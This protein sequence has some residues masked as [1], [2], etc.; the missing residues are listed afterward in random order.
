MFER[1]PALDRNSVRESQIAHRL[2]ALFDVAIRS[3][4]RIEVRGLENFTQAP[5]TLVVSNHRR[6]SDG[7]IIASV[8]LQREKLRVRGVM[9]YFV[10]REDLFR[11]G[12]LREYLE[13]WPSPVRAALSGLD[14]APLLQLMQAAPMRRV[15]ERSLMEVLEEVLEVFGDLRLDKVLKP[16]WVRE[17]ER[18]AGASRNQPLRVSDVLTWRYHKLLS[19]RHGLLKLTRQR[20][21]ALLP[22]ERAIIESQL[23]FFTRLLE[24]GQTLLLE[25]EGTVSVDGRFARLRAGL[26][27]LL[28]RPA[29]PPRVLPVGITYDFIT[30]NPKRVL[31]SVGKEMRNLQ[32]LSRK[33]TDKRVAAAI[34]GQ[35]CITCSQ[36]ASDLLFQVR[37]RGDA[38]ITGSEIDCYVRQE[39]SRYAQAGSPVD[40]RLLTEDDR[41]KRV[42]EYIRHCLRNRILLRRGRDRYCLAENGQE[43]QPSADP[44]GDIIGYMHNELTTL[45]GLMSDRAGQT[46]PPS[47][48]GSSTGTSG[49]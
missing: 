2:A 39:A 17:F 29:M 6:D 4:Y 40:S 38:S 8:L 35:L 14:L 42:R 19:R 26:H 34:Q 32:G 47:W 15:P 18:A 16:S 45:G 30:D 28:N 36:L 10:A 9:P 11:R 43:M 24:E 1:I 46:L 37:N 27:A 21:R 7:P 3:L 48:L 31:V 22:H 25:P 33:E 41:V 12:F 44:T 5:S 13:G 20:F 49:G 23:D